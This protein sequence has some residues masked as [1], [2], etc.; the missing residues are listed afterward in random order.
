MKR[1]RESF[2]KNTKNYDA[3][4][5]YKVTECNIRFYVEAERRS[6]YEHDRQESELR[7]HII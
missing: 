5:L 3:R 4:A 6:N 2:P 7:N 1:E